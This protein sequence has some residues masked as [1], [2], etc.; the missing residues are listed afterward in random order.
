MSW[1]S[2]GELHS[3]AWTSSNYAGLGIL[4][5]NLP[6]TGENGGSPLLNDGGVN[7]D[8]VRWELL[9][10]SGVTLNEFNEDGSF[11]S[12]G[13][14]SFT[15]RSFI[16]NSAVGDFTVTVDP[17][18][19]AYSLTCE[20]VSDNHSV[21]DVS[22]YRNYLML[23]DTVTDSHT[24]ETITL[25]YT[26]PSGTAYVITCDSVADN[27]QAGAVIFN[28]GYVMRADA[29]SDS[30]L[31]LPVALR[32]SGEEI[33]LISTY[34]VNYKQSLISVSYKQTSLGVNYGNG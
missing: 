6:A 31:A 23:C 10:T 22:F 12:D 28:R 14:G 29:V 24:A 4:F 25:T 26:T 32:Y 21:G 18:T 16:N 2:G 13:T 7:G 8:E 33:V 1:L 19:T 3:G 20:N 27:H 5:E 9:T 11:V 34:S 30:H 15:Y 17:L